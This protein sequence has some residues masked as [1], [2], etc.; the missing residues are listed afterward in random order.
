M[1]D[2]TIKICMNMIVKNESR[3][4]LRLLQSILPI[5]DN[6]VICDTGSTDNTKELITSF[7]S[8]HGILGHVVEEPFRDFGYNRS[9]ALQKADEL[10]PECD[11]ILLLDADMVFKYASASSFRAF[12]ETGKTDGIDAFHIFQGDDA[13]F[14]K[15]TRV[16]RTGIGA[17]YWGVTHE[18]V[19]LRD[20]SQYRLMPKDVAFIH[21]IGDGGAKADKFDRDIRLL[22]QGL[23]DNPTSERYMFYLANSYRD[24]GDTDLAIDM[25]KRRIDAKGWF[26][27][28]WYAMYNLGHCY[29]SKGDMV[30]AVHWWMEAYQLFPQRVENL[31]EIVTYY[32]QQG[33]N[34]LAY[35]FYAMAAKQ[36]AANPHP[37]YLFL[38]KDVYEYKLAYEMTILGYYCNPD[39]INLCRLS[40]EVMNCPLTVSPIAKNVMSNYKFYAPKYAD[41]GYPFPGQQTIDDWILSIETGPEFTSSTPSIVR[42]STYED[43]DD[44][45]ILRYAVCVRFVNYRITETGMY[46]N[47]EKIA[48]INHIAIVEY[49][50]ITNTCVIESSFEMPYDTSIDNVYVGLEDVRLFSHRHHL[51]YNANRGLGPHH[52]VVEHGRVLDP[53]ISGADFDDLDYDLLFHSVKKHAVEKNWVFFSDNEGTIRVI[54]EWHNLSIGVLERGSAPHTRV[55]KETHSI[56][57]PPIFKW[58]RGSTNGVKIGDEIWFICHVVSHED[59]RNYYHMF[60]AIDSDTFEVVKYSTLFTFTGAKVEYTLG[61]IHDE[62]QGAF[63]IGYSVMDNTTRFLSIAEKTVETEMIYL[64]RKK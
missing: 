31:W 21:D 37:D 36:V 1:S 8:G 45:A 47:Q 16:V 64:Q 18:Y 9:F 15:N 32:R 27:E 43:D 10:F 50:H 20:N 56:A 30:T 52:I 19:N 41:L 35:L 2:T 25:Y 4:I 59:R 5:V 13:Y 46:E 3:I 12:L 40:M 42:L 6:Y 22:K 24:H 29:K 49:N 54:Y 38:K 23:V 57:S 28:I 34:Q 61:F 11:Y 39:N 58:V 14:Y 33:K 7:F 44:A 51:L 60:V 17:S 48:T 62:Y 63:H 55:F 53:T 26:E